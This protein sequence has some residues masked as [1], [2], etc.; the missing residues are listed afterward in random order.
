MNTAARSVQGT[1]ARPP[2]P[3]AAPW[4]YVSTRSQ[5]RCRDQPVAR[6]DLD[7]DRSGSATP[8]NDLRRGVD[9]HFRQLTLTATHQLLACRPAL[10]DECRP[11]PSGQLNDLLSPGE[12]P[13]DMDRHDRTRDPAPDHQAAAVFQRPPP[14]AL[15]HPTKPSGDEIALYVTADVIG[16]I[17]SRYDFQAVR[18]TGLA[19]GDG[20]STALATRRSRRRLDTP[21]CTGPHF[22]FRPPPG[23]SRSPEL[24]AGRATK[25]E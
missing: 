17:A 12:R 10:L 22:R 8:Q 1:A 16:Q 11:R 13:H 18:E 15:N 24:I 2:S 4:R 25:M 14:S 7:T 9:L 23:P 20:Q 6:Q 21:P 3:S 19:A 5:S